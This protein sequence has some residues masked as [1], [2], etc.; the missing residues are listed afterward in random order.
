MGGKTTKEKKKFGDHK[1]SGMVIRMT[2][3]WGDSPNLLL[4][5]RKREKEEK[6]GEKKSK[7][8]LAS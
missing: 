1:K 8:T 4:P 5:S 2:P 3:V 7:Q 6:K